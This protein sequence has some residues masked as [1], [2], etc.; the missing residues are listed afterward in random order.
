MGDAKTCKGLKG[1]AGTYTGARQLRTLAQ[2]VEAMSTTR[3]MVRARET[4]SNPRTRKRLLRAVL[5]V[6]RSCCI[7]H[8]GAGAPR[9]LD[10]AIAMRTRQVAKLVKFGI[11]YAQ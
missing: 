7:E 3:S 8:G 4:F 6:G 11:A 10:F 5:S 9:A 2:L 1:I